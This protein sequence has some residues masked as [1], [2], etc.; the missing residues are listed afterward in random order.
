MPLVE[1]HPTQDN[2]LPMLGF[3]SESIR[4]NLRATG[5]ELGWDT[6]VL[7]LVDHP[8]GVRVL[9]APPPG[10]NV[11]PL[12][13][14]QALSLLLAM[15]PLALVDAASELDARVQSALLAADLILL[16]MTPEVPA[17][18][19][20]LR[21]MQALRTLEFPERQIL[22]VVNNLLPRAT[23]P[24]DQIRKGMR[25]PIFAVIPYEPGMRDVS[26]AGR[27]LL[28]AQPR[29]PAAQ[30]I[31]RISVQLARGFKLSTR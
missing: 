28:V 15:F 21:A 7:H 26:R 23:V 8:S 22:L 4:G 25:R 1:L 17:I 20:T 5:H 9:P 30:A 24:I 3:G 31:G 11:P 6:L 27:P 18:R 14:R 29:S 19:A 2:L 13:T 10:S 12:L 16:V